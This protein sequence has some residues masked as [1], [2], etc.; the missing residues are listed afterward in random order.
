M[1][2]IVMSSDSS[3]ALSSGHEQGCAR[4]NSG[5][6]VRQK[7]GKRGG[8]VSRPGVVQKANK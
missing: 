8:V 6:I 2:I 1:H 5:V 3:K 7:R 4:G